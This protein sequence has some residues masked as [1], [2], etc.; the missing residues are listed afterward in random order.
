MKNVDSDRERARLA[1]FYAGQLDGELQ[2][3]AGQAWELTDL[4]R[5]V[6]KVELEK[7][8]LSANL[9]NEP[10]Q[11]ELRFEKMVM[12][13][14]FRDLP[15]AL[16]AKGSL[17]SAGIASELIDDNI[18]RLD[19]FLSNLMG[20]V[21]LLVRPGD[22]DSAQEILDQPIP[23]E[24]DTAGAGSYE[25][26]RCP[27]CQSLDISFEELNKPVA[28]LT[29]YL[30]I[31]IPVHLEAWRCHSCE[32]QWEETGGAGPSPSSR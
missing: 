14:R 7:R 8:G 2:Q 18:V 4:A 27:L 20:G 13:R 9:A 5:E 1:A 31:P 6:L 24:F 22:L 28:Y 17:D 16:L 32:A 19:W 26:P 10:S 12:I 11:E 15:E 25:Q 23:A 29:A 3:V 21:K 30:G